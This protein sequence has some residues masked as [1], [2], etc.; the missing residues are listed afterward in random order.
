MSYVNEILTTMLLNK[1]LN[2]RN[3]FR[4]HAFFIQVSLLR[5]LSLKINKNHS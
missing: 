3:V 2:K 5:V 1:E 4:S